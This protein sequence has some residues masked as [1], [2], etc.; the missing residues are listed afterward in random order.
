MENIK[1]KLLEYQR[2]HINNII[3]IFESLTIIV[4]IIVIIRAIIIK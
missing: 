4:D 2:E 1:H 3:R